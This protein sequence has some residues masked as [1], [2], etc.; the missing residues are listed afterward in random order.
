[1]ARGPSPA[2]TAPWDVKPLAPSLI[3]LVT[4]F[5][6]WFATVINVY[7][8]AYYQYRVGLL[9]EDRW[10]MHL[11]GLKA[12]FTRWPGARQWWATAEYMFSSPEFFAL[13]EEILG[14]EPEHAD[15]PQ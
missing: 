5:E 3:S 6:F 11:A 2:R 10:Q 15:R 1:M 7:D 4:L 13:V 9:D 12:T 8:N 14:E